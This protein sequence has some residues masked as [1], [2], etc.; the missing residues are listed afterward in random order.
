MTPYFFYAC[1]RVKQGSYRF[2][3][4]FVSL[5]GGREMATNEAESTGEA[6]IGIRILDSV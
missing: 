3:S 6:E 4:V 2:D 5:H 1:T